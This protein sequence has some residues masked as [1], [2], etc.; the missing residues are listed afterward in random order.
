[1]TYKGK[2]SRR[3]L[4]RLGM[5]GTAVSVANL[6]LGKTAVPRAK[7]SPWLEYLGEH[8]VYDNPKPNLFSRHGCFPGLVQL[9][10]GELICLFVLA[11]AFDAANGT[12]HITRSSDLGKT[13]KL[14]G[15]LYDKTVVGFLTNDA[16]KATLL[17]DGTLV[18]AGYRFHRLD[19]EG[20]IADEKTGGVLPGDDL[21]A[22]SSDEARTWTV[23]VVIPRRRP[24]L[25]E[26]SGPCIQLRS[27]DL[28]AVAGFMPL[29][30][31]TFPSGNQG[32]ILRSGDGGKTWD[33]T[34]TCFRA[35]NVAAWES[36]VCE[37]QPGRVVAILWSYDFTT[38]NHLPNHVVVSHDDGRTW[39][40]PINTGIMAQASSL[41]WIKGNLLLSIHAHRAENPGLYVRLVDFTDDKWKVLHEKIIWGR[42]I[43]QQTKHGQS[44]EKMFTSIRFGQP[45]LVRLNNREIL[46]THWSIEGGQGRIRTHRLR[47]PR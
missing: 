20:A 27:G 4:I 42:Q 45:S 44:L 15:K 32:I 26:I 18:A 12:T 8:I 33:D 23:P 6:A 1:M 14:Q 5:A 3:E 25:Y 46:A 24:E 34:V 39:G 11:E 22:F 2:L 10:S 41:L 17:R 7:A 36:R 19:P 31:G 21:V 30:N 38:Q 13:W 43:G 9:A 16:M 47:L 37:M 35:G 29:P 28:L 40:E